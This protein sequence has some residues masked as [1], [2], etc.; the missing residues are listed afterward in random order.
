M[1]AMTATELTAPPPRSESPITFDSGIPSRSAPTAIARPLPGCSCSD[2][3]FPAAERLR[4]F[5]P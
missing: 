4:C 5:A 1:T 2:G 3:C